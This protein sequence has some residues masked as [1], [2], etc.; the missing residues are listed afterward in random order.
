MITVAI[1]ADDKERRSELNKLIGNEAD[2]HL[3]AAT[4]REDALL[5]AFIGKPDVLLLDATLIDET[6][7]ELIRNIQFYS[8]DICILVHV[9][10]ES[11]KQLFDCINAGADGYLLREDDPHNLIN[12]IRDVV[13]GGTPLTS[14][15]ARRMFQWIKSGRI[16]RTGPTDKLSGREQQI[17]EHLV[18]GKSH[19]MIAGE[20]HISAFTVS[21][22][23]KK[24]FRKLNVHSVSEVVATA[25]SQQI[26]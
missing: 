12:G 5:P 22:H 18:R 1:V 13:K 10:I 16:A 7:L 4:E 9:A 21:N 20:L 11:D 3:V 14:T 24:I 8:P 2:M 23:V 26:V 6:H 17:L 19:K 25:I 15:V